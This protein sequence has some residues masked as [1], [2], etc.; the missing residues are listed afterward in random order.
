MLRVE[1]D[2]GNTYII[3][4]IFQAIP[5]GSSR[6]HMTIC[7]QIREMIEL[8]FNLFTEITIDGQDIIIEVLDAN[9]SS[10][11]A[12]SLHKYLEN[13]FTRELYD[14]LAE[15]YHYLNNPYHLEQNIP[16]GQSKLYHI[17]SR[18]INISRRIK[19]RFPI[20]LLGDVNNL[21]KLRGLRILDTPHIYYD[22]GN[23]CG[24]H[25]YL[26]HPKD[27][28]GRITIY[29]LRYSLSLFTDG[30][31]TLVF[32][33][34]VRRHRLSELFHQFVL[35][36]QKKH[37]FLDVE[38]E[39]TVLFNAIERMGKRN[40]KCRHYEGIHLLGFVIIPFAHIYIRPNLVLSKKIG[41]HKAKRLFIIRINGQK[42][43]QKGT[44]L[45]GVVAKTNWRGRP[46]YPILQVCNFI[47][48]MGLTV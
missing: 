7:R 28:W 1:F 9:F 6:I 22:S 36:K 44:P 45:I 12:V 31:L 24:L 25:M 3:R 48:G 10:A 11:I 42:G 30:L 17:L 2:G 35:G 19:M 32:I 46:P 40:R 47:K 14:H 33:D 21:N 26:V 18:G 37:Y 4:N 15:L 43:H 41:K 27:L 29:S 23:P 20:V 13:I 8:R 38:I 39:N 16:F 5:I 34:K